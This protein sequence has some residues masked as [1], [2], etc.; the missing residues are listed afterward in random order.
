MAYD[1]VLFD[2]PYCHKISNLAGYGDALSLSVGGVRLTIRSRVGFRMGRR[3]ILILSVKSILNISTRAKLWGVFAI[4]LVASFGLHGCSSS[5]T[6][7]NADPNAKGKGGGGGRGRGRSLDGGGP[8]PVVV[9][10]VGQKDVPIELTVVGNVEA[11]STITVIPQVG[12]QLTDVY[13]QEGDYVKKGDKLFTIDQRPLAAQL[14]QAQANMA[15]DNAL[16]NQSQANLAR[17]TASEVYARAEAGR[18]AKLFDEK[19]VSRE[20]ADQYKT[21]ADTLVQSLSADRAAIESAKAQIASDQA[22]IDNAKVQLSYTTIPS[23]I[24][25]R[26]GNLMFKLGN[27]VSANQTNLITI[28]Q[29][30]PIYVT[31][32]VPE[33][34]L[35]DVKRYMAQGKLPVTA[36]TQDGQAEL[37]RGVLSFVDNNVDMTTG[38]IKLKGTFQ[39]T[40][41]R[42]WPGQYVNVVLRETTR[43]HALVVPNQAVQ[44]GQDGSFVYV[45]KPDRTVTVAKVVTG[46]RVDQDLVVESGLQ[47]GDTVVTEGQLR[48][49]PGSRVQARDAAAAD[50]G[51]GGR[52]G[53]GRG[54]GGG[55]GM[56]AGAGGG[57]RGPNADGSIKSGNPARAE[58]AS[59][60]GGDGV[61]G[62]HGGSHAGARHGG[63]GSRGTGPNPGGGHEGGKG[64]RRGAGTG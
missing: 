13:F 30:E 46:P 64:K 53:G 45:V 24:D 60:A 54:D 25:G 56:E 52:R 32:A 41:R 55:R 12:G 10:K 51:G 35:S 19:I 9:A 20:Q 62:R 21:N 50:G 59:P 43:P 33:A 39:N 7:E 3:S 1:F 2:A 8:V 37:E 40:N 23:P 57:M 17:D 18:Y 15:R 27:V 28:T 4:I 38:T 61:E 58:G 36:L 34:A 16:L 6:A 48:L 5:P 49:A 31:F 26:T 42:L 47:E 29:V 11:Y 14:A 22:A 44:S 63:N